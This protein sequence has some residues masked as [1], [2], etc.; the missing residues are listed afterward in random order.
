M[1]QMQ[2]R[3][4]TFS[5][6]TLVQLK[7]H[8]APSTMIVGDFNTPLSP[9]DTSWKHNLNRDTSKLKEVMKQTVLTDIY[10]TFFFLKQK[11][12]PSSQHLMVPSPNLTVY[13]V[14][15]HTSTHTNILKL[16]NSSYQI[17]MN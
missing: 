14:T 15:K 7:V 2:A 4:A 10:R 9:M 3:P 5:K 11:D 8:I 1:L 16:S 17:T 12:I 6:E 13:L